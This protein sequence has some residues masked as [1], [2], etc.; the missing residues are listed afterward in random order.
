MLTFDHEIFTGA[1]HFIQHEQIQP[2]NVLNP[3]LQYEATVYQYTYK[4]MLV[5]N[6]HCKHV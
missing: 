5:C 6:N 1:R 4:Y 3:S 2:K